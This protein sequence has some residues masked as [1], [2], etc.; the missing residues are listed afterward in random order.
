MIEYSVNQF[1]IAEFVCQ[2]NLR[3]SPTFHCPYLFPL[4]IIK[5]RPWIS[6][7]HFHIVSPTYR[8]AFSAMDL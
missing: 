1:G 2:T 5:V 4:T 3:I 8:R 6:A 7:T